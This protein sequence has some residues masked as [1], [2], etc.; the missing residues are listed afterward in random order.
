MSGPLIVLV[1]PMGVGKSTV[2]ELLAERLGSSY[3][4]TDA[5]VVAA[6]GK[7]IPEIFFDEG[8]ER[9]RALERQAVR[10]A[11]AG[12]TGVLALGGG[13][14]LDGETRA[15]LAGRPVVYLSMDVDEAVR[16]VGLNTARPLLAVNPRRQ[17]RELMD[18]RR[19]LYEEVATVTVATDARTPEEVAQAVL[20]AMELPERTVEAVPSGRENTRMTEQGTTRI[21]IAGTAGTDPYEVLVGRQLLGELPNLIGD[22][23]KRVAVLHPEALAETGEA[24]RAD[25]A[26][27]GYEAIAIQLP[28]A[29]EAKTVEVAA[30]CWKALGQTGF[31]RTDVIVGVGGGATTDV[32]GFVAAS[33]LRGVPWIAVPTTVLAMVDAAVGGKTGINTAEGKN[34]VGAFH[35]PTGVL[36]DLAALDSLPVHDYVSGMAEIIKAGFIADPVILDLV[37]ADPQG[38]RTPAGPHTAE[39]IERSIRVK[40]EVV[41]SD[42]KESGL[43]EI[44]NYGHTLAHAIEKNERYKWRHGAAVSVGMVFAAELGRLAGRLDDATADRHRAVLES[45]GLPLTYRGD[46]WPKLLE[47]MKV[48]KKSRGDLLRFIV[49]DG[50]GKPTVLEGPDP[51]VLLAAYGEVSA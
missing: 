36:C 49:L 6:A 20:D 10:D 7:A 14:V 9:F 28:N 29:E 51:A 12:H 21:Q 40:A 38:A 42:L 1:G 33:W 3:R 47:N 37:E 22:R 50:V 35:P 26:A 32:A 27:Q 11:I 34:L 13:A 19:P 25:L 30:Y 2:G 41:G 15:L 44:L 24:V 18:A 45:V 17:W 23:A 48:D 4:D 46:Q 5:D 16:R 8:E 39:L 43:R 31:T